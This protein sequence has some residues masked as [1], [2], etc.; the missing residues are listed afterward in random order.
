[1]KSR[2]KNKL[3]NNKKNNRNLTMK[4]NNKNKS[5]KM[6]MHKNKRKNTKSTCKN[7]AI[8]EY[9]T[10]QEYLLT[11]NQATSKSFSKAIMWKE[12]IY[13]QK[14]NG[15]ERIVSKEEATRR[16]ALDKVGLSFQ[17]KEWQSLHLWLWMVRRW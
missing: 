7:W 4:L 8:E 2:V 17:I 11:W 5:L 13:F 15:P 16:Y 1:M 9:V 12:Y 14:A 10:C 6:R 3:S